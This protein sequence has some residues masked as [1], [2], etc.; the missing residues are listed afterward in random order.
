MSSETC[1]LQ[2]LEHARRSARFL[3]FLGLFLWASLGF[4]LEAAH[5]FKLSG[6]LDQVQ[7]RE[8]LVWAHAHGVG[9]ALVLLAYAGQ[10]VCDARSIAAGPYLRFGAFGMPLG[11]AL[12]IFHTSESDPGPAIWLVP[13]AA[14][15]LLVGLAKVVLSARQN[16]H[17]PLA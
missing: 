16:L 7:R 4:L 17:S 10:G 6:Y 2:S 14:A 1:D 12:S 5:A 3:G 8:L 13:I 11:F 15:A 9:L